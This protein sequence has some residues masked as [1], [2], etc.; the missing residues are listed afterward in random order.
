MRRMSWARVVALVGLTLGCG[1]TEVESPKGMRPAPP[2][3]GVLTE[4]RPQGAGNGSRGVGED[5]TGQGGSACLSGVCLHVKPGREQGYVCSQPC[6]TPGDCPSQWRCAQLY[7]T[8]KGRLCTPP[9]APE[10]DAAAL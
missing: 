4:H 5:C 7:P 10:A 1:T 3:A 8:P 9:S 2:R 6:Q